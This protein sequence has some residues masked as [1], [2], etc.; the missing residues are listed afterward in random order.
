[1]FFTVH[2]RKYDIL[3]S[4][5]YKIIYNAI[6]IQTKLHILIIRIIYAVSLI[7]RCHAVAP[8]PQKTTAA[9]ANTNR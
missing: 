6:M 3:M 8:V 5:Q 7:C 9:Y 1:M 2:I 4:F